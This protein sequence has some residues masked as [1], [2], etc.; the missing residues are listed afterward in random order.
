MTFKKHIYLLAF[1]IISCG[2]GG[3][4]SQTV[5]PMIPTPPTPSSPS[6]PTIWDIATP[7]TVGMNP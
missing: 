2:G 6:H 7:E 5:A 3:S 1:L 4:S